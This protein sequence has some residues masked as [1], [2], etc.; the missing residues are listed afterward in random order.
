MGEE[1]GVLGVDKGDEA[2][3]VRRVLGLLTHRG[4]RSVEGL[5]ESS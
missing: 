5:P 3:L 2:S 1:L 4:L